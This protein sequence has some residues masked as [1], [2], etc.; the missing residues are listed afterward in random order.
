MSDSA[1]E[2]EDFDE[3]WEEEEED[4]SNMPEPGAIRLR[5]FNG[6]PNEDADEHLNN[7]K[8]TMMD[9]GMVGDRQYC[10]RFQCADLDE[11]VTTL[12]AKLLAGTVIHVFRRVPTGRLPAGAESRHVRVVLRPQREC[13]TVR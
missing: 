12:S 9:H 2:E 6:N 11:V 5:K 13:G 7:F 1:F 10:E 3:F 4:C 8:E